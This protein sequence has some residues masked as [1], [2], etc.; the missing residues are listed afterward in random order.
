M[1]L[2]SPTALERFYRFSRRFTPFAWQEVDE[3]HARI[4]ERC[5]NEA[6]CRR[7]CEVS[8]Q[9]TAVSYPTPV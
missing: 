1:D 7:L 9:L 3:K 8:E 2:A 5:Q 4:L 6:D